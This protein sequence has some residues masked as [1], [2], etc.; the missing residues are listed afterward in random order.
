MKYFF[1]LFVITLFSCNN[2]QQKIKS[3]SFGAID[4]KIIKR[5]FL[6]NVNTDA[7]KIDTSNGYFLQVDLTVRNNSI[8]TIKFDTSFFRLINDKG[9]AFPFSKQMNEM[10]KN[11]QPS[12]Y[13]VMLEPKT[14][15]DGF[16][17][18]NVPIIVDYKLQ[19]NSGDWNKEKT[20]IDLNNL[21]SKKVL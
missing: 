3:V 4:Y 15:K 2:S 16:I 1:A 18:F 21:E 20:E 11:F 14:E 13:D 6:S 10:M 12:L 19:V 9:Q 5:S 7:T 8:A 17:I